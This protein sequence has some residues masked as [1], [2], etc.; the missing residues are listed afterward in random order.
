MMHPLSHHGESLSV[1]CGPFAAGVVA[2][3]RTCGRS[4]FFFMVRVCAT[5][6]GCGHSVSV[7]T[8]SRL[9]SCFDFQLFFQLKSSYCMVIWT[10]IQWWSCL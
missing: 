7:F 4:L 6:P 1:H 2:V 9:E 8:V 10:I 3:L 5:V